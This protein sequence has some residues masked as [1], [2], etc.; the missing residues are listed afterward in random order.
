MPEAPAQ[1]F[2]A[3]GRSLRRPDGGEKVAGATRFAADIRLPGMLHCRLV[4]S[5]HAHARIRRVDGKAAAALPAVIGVYTARDLPLANTDPA[6]RNRC[7][8]ALDRAQFVGHPVAAVVAETEAAAEDGAALVEVEYEEMPAAVEPLDAMA[9]DAPRVRVAEG[10]SGEEALAMHGAGGAAQAVK[11]TT[12][13]NVSSTTHFTRGDVAKGFAESTVIVERTYTTPVVHQGY[14]EPRAAVANLEPTGQL[15]VWTTTQALFYTR[16]E[17]AEA[18]GLPEHQV[19]VIATPL[20]GGFGGK[21]I[22][23]EPLVAALALKL[24]RPVGAVMTRTEEF[25]AATPAPQCRIEVKTGARQDGTLAAVEGRIVFDAGAFPGAPVMIAALMLGGYYRFEHMDI[26]GYEVLTHK[27]GQ[28]AYRAPGAVQASFAIE[29]Q[30]DEMARALGIDALDF[31]IRNCVVEGDPMNNGRTWPR[32]GLRQV[33]E[34]LREARDSRRPAPPTPSSGGRLRRGVGL[35]VGGWMGGI[36]PANAV[37]RLD[38]DGT[39]TIVLGTVDMSGTNTAF[40]QIAAEA[41]GLPVDSI[42]VVNPDSESAPYAG[43]SGGSKITY[44]VGAAVEKAAR[45]AREQLFRIAADHLEASVADLELVDKK[46]RVRGVPDGGV[47][48]AALAKLS[49]QFGAKYEPVLGRGASATVQR[50]PA[51]AAH[52]AEVEVDTDTGRTRV[53]SHLVVQDVGRAINP[54]AIEGQIQGAVAQGVGWALFEKMA[55][56]EAGQLLSATFMD[57]ALPQ[58]D[59]V[60]LVDTILVEVPSELGPYGAKGV[61]EPPVIAAP[62]AIAN[63]IRDATGARLTELPITGEALR[64]ALAS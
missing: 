58:S 31:R 42:R 60:P 56:D 18:L 5:P 4:L 10:G 49:M 61:G 19:R 12:G 40:G 38:R 54:A 34:R 35:A 32:I 3:V 63:A 44:T 6:D 27:V 45:D 17:V 2:S 48:V 21:F 30:M 11:E 20:G 47:E 43:S 33:L 46:I 25:L 23:L 14:L 62:A 1:V 52:L 24:R 29:S 8:L 13:P 64:R 51:F 39:L 28:G 41:F 7:P 36:E 55:Y 53:I 57:Y 16:S 37:C 59:Q 22:L 50:A 15:T 26:K 9:M